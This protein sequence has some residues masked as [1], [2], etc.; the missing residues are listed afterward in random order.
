MAE[1]PELFSIGEEFDSFLPSDR[2]TITFDLQT[3][4]IFG[5]T[6]MMFFRLLHQIFSGLFFWV[7]EMVLNDDDDD[8]YD[9]EEGIHPTYNNTASELFHDV[10]IFQDRMHDNV[11][12]RR[13]QMEANKEEINVKRG[14]RLRD[15]KLLPPLVNYGCHERV[16]NCGECAIC[17]EEFEVGQFCQ[18]FCGCKHIF[19]SDCIDYWLQTKL[20]CPI[21]RSCVTG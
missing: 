3:S 18:V 10:V 11:Q 1:F 4:I 8:Q 7:N 12:T 5:I 14:K 2:F 9:L 21:C 6:A 19:H 13:M 15:L 17:L 20:T 16:R